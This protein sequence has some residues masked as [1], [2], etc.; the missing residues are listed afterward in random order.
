LSQ[1]PNN[2]VS[3]SEQS[4]K[5]ATCGYGDAKGVTGRALEES[6]TTEIVV[7]YCGRA[8]Q[9]EARLTEA[10]R[11]DGDHL[12]RH[13]MLGCGNKVETL[14]LLKLVQGGAAG[15]LVVC[16]PFEECQF[17]TGSRHAA[18]RVSHAR[19]LL[20]EIGLAADRI[21]FV[22]RCGLSQDDVAELVKKHLLTLE[23]LSGTAA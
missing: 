13:V 5:S 4:Q 16:C 20:A 1:F 17:V 7:L 23:N 2:P 12:V 21:K 19:Q 6:V 10:S 15:V 8:V 14:D 18:G 22:P 3:I 11:R 9:P